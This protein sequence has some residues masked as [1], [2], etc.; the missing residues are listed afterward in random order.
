MI[1]III[2][3][4]LVIIQFTIPTYLSICYTVKGHPAYSWHGLNNYHSGIES[5]A[6]G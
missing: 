6:I 3:S 5:N 1:I 4:I 2:I